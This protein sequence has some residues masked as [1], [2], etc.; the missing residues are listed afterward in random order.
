MSLLLTGIG[1][2]HGI[3][4]GKVHL[5]QRGEPDIFEYSIHTDAID[6]EVQRFRNALAL[7]K[8]QLRNL[9]HTIPTDT[10]PDVAEFID[11][12][13]LMLDD[14]LLSKVPELLI[15][16]RQCNA[17]WAL[18]LQRDEIVAVFDQM[19]DP[20]LRTRRNDVDHVIHR[21]QRILLKQEHQLSFSSNVKKHII[22]ADDLT[23]ADIVVLQHQGIAG[24]ITES[25][26][27][28]SHTA[29]LAR[30]L[31]IPAVVGIHNALHLLRNDE[32]VIIDADKGMVASE[33][34]N[35]IVKTY[36]QY[37][38][39]HRKY[40]KQLTSFRHIPAVTQDGHS[41]HLRA[42]IEVKE[43]IRA[44]K[45]VGAEG[46]GLYRTEFLFLDR[47]RPADESEQLHSYRRII[48]ALKGK[49]LTIRTVDLG[50]DKEPPDS[51]AAL[52]PCL[53]PALGLR[54]M[55][56]SLK[57]INL[58]SQQLRAILRASA[59][60][61]VSIMFP[62]LTSI[63]E[64]H[65]ALQVLEEAKRELIG[66][67]LRFDEN[68]SVG[69]MIEVPA[70]AL[71]AYAFAKQVDFLSIG[72]N[73]L[74]QYTLAIDRLD[75]E[76][77]YLYDPLH[78]AVLRLIHMILQAAK[79]ADIPV[80]MC[81]EM[82]GETRYTRLL[83]GMGLREFSTPPSALLEVKQAINA[84]KLSDLD[85]LCKRILASQEPEQIASL[86]DELNK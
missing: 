14:N 61:P 13:L 68:L 49:P 83:L 41:I 78:P 25:G 64:L 34:D 18:K 40:R 80:S 54:A 71:T 32:R 11:T 70:A 53:N 8:K 51:Y 42:N 22:V 60:G 30:G 24:F 69:A 9:R 65:Q 66:K 35:K 10:P 39:D 16:K 55:R 2:S 36:R 7:A 17:E 21:V 77:N 62:M 85:K 57:D 28:L 58:F 12:H 44:L 23:P 29:I 19:Q 1:V 20:Y 26:G 86:V 3:A 75:D 6:S 84:S 56:R 82:A 47:E 52:T 38:R 50:A 31:D 81:G 63:H 76:V 4:I 45:Q 43:D 73:D 48:K 46:V 5:L 59:Y 37:Q 74:I 72:T 27:P 67:K 79:K 15:R 33:V